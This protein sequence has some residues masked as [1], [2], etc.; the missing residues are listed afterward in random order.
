MAAVD[1]SLA[2]V[3]SRIHP[4]GNELAVEEVSDDGGKRPEC[5]DST[6]QECLF[7]LT[8]TMSIGMSAFLQG[9]C[10][11]ITAPIGRSLNMTSAQITWI[12]ASSAYIFIPIKLSEVYN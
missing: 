7:I 12:N 10:T 3:E 11:V 5:F 6:L 4:T 9:I 8:A 2:V 1:V